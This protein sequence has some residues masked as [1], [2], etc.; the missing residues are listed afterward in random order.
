MEA[1]LR[2]GL[3]ALGLPCSAV[4][5]PLHFPGRLLANNRVLNL[6]TTTE[7]LLAEI[8]DLLKEQK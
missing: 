3:T 2:A 1:T 5:R 8:R 7:E 4:P 6:T